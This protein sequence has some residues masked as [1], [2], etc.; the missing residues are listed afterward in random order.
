MCRIQKSSKPVALI[1]TVKG[2]TVT[3][4]EHPTQKRELAG[5]SAFLMDGFVC[6]DADP[7]NR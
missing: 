2:S 4:V 5:S 3:P 7:S 6:F 1:K